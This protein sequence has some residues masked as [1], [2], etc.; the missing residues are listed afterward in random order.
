M[1]L[2]SRHIL[3]NLLTQSMLDSSNGDTITCIEN[4]ECVASPFFIEMY[5][6]YEMLQAH[7]H[8]RHQPK[9]FNMLPSSL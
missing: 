9:P 2:S 1:C 7:N 3:L 5:D 6:A 8:R 4:N